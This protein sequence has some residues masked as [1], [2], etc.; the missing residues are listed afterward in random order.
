MLFVVCSCVKLGLPPTRFCDQE[1]FKK[2]WP[3]HKGLHT[4]IKAARAQMVTD[5]TKL[6]V[7]Y[8]S[9]NYRFTGDLRPA[10]QT[11]RRTVPA[12]I[13][14]PDYASHP[15][16]KSASEEADKAGNTSIR[17]YNQE[18]IDGMREVCRIGRKVLDIG[19]RA[20]RVG[21]TCDEIDRV[22]HEATVAEG[23][24]PSPLNYYNFPKSVCTS[25]NE[26][27]CHGIP[28]MRELVDGDIV[29]IDVTV[30]K[31]GYHADL[32]ETFFVGPKATADADS[33]RLLETA[34]NSLAA[35]I[36]SCK[37]GTLYRDLG[38]KITAVAKQANCSVVTSYCGHGIGELFHTAPTIPHYA[39]NKAKGAMM[40]GHIFT[41]E[42]MINL[43]THNDVLWPDGWTSC[44]ADGKR[45]AQ[46]EHTMVV[47]ETGV[48]LLT[49]REGEPLDRLAPWDVSRFAR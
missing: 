9:S 23:G 21:V 10:K 46:Y 17:V 37:P 27:I 29:N 31:N 16:G 13:R 28:D 2:S 49:A 30:Y 19:G 24:Y 43:G 18:Q 34:Y 11:A 48:E 7:D 45:S 1:C 26:V 40:P 22:V 25:V 32:N 42:P 41:I 15:M 47:T 38:L 20:V 14:H 5:P 33:V 8:E 39:N 36:D 12:E 6:A 44:T 4:A 35:A 3:T